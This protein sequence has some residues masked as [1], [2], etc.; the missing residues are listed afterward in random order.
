MRCNIGRCYNIDG[1][2]SRNIIP[3]NNNILINILSW[4]NKTSPLLRVYSTVPIS[5]NY[6]SARRV[7]AVSYDCVINFGN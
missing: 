5:I 7:M 4:N 6:C 3:I 2:A 1:S